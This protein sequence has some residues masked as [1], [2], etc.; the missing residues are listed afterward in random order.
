M[1]FSDADIRKEVQRRLMKQSI[2]DLAKDLGVSPAMIHQVASGK[3]P[4]GPTIAE[5]LGFHDDGLR[6]VRD[7]GVDDEA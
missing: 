4:P 3:A 1:R 7:Y 6:W 5:A 2:R